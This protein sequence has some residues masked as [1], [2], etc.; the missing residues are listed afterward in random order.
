MSVTTETLISSISA[1]SITL[2]SSKTLTILTEAKI[3]ETAKGLGGVMFPNPDGFITDMT[4]DPQSFGTGGSEK[5]DIRYSLHY[6]F[7]DVPVGSGRSL[8]SNYD[9][10]L[11]DTLAIINKI[12]VSDSLSGAVTV[13]FGGFDDFGIISDP[14]G[15]QFFGAVIAFDVLQFFEV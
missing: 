9:V 2:R 6:V 13:K 10:L 5:M 15:G 12:A 4:I 1:L 7:C 14:V 11:A 3:P 8:G